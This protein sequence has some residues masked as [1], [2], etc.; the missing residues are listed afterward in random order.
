MT[1]RFQAVTDI[2]SVTQ[3][4]RMHENQYSPSKVTAIVAFLVCTLA[5]LIQPAHA[6]FVSTGGGVLAQ[7]PYTLA[8]LATGS[9]EAFG[10]EN[11]ATTIQR[12][13]SIAGTFI[14][15]YAAHAF[16]SADLGSGQ[17]KI[18]A[19][20]AGITFA[21][22]TARF[23]DRIYLS[24]PYNGCGDGSLANPFKCYAIS[25]GLS[26]T[27]TLTGGSNGYAELVAGGNIDG[28]QLR[29]DLASG[30]TSQSGI[31]H[32][33]RV[34]TSPQ[35]AFLDINA[36]LSGGSAAIYYGAGILDFSNTAAL[37]LDLPPGVTFTSE[38]GVFLTAVPVPAAVWLF[39]SGLLGLIGI[40]RRRSSRS[41]V[42]V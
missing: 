1:K 14:D 12:D 33:T 21:S 18:L 10:G 5:A 32:T 6:Y 22:A 37:T 19:D 40:A 11:G 2:Y 9:L 27:G 8:F 30:T 39:G 24:G 16:A 26:A 4:R 28:A 7:N 29:F 25:V 34:L 23:S 3:P 41:A 13:A 15:P 31:A 36:T 38:S 20:S 42:A 35:P 17:L